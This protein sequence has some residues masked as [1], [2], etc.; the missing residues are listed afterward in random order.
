MRTRQVGSVTHRFFWPVVLVEDLDGL[1]G[2]SVR[3][4]HDDR[5]AARALSIRRVL[6]RLVELKCFS[7]FCAMKPID[8]CFVVHT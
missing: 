1:L 5:V 6:H 4:E 3:Q 7:F 2:A 8:F